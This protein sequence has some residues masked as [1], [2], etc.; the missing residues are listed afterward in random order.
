MI[1]QETNVSAAVFT[2]FSIA[3]PNVGS[4]RNVERAPIFQRP[5]SFALGRGLSSLDSTFQLT[6]TWFTA[7]GRLGALGGLARR[8]LTPRG[9]LR[10]WSGVV[11]S[12]PVHQDPAPHPSSTKLACRGKGYGGFGRSPSQ[13]AP[14][15]VCKDQ[16]GA[17]VWRFRACF[18]VSPPLVWS[19]L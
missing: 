19:W 14:G 11:Q 9:R 15:V 6:P 17:G 13:T 16:Q 3:P 5:F 1:D 7:G 10:V 8:V 18:G 12:Q 4:K 2:I